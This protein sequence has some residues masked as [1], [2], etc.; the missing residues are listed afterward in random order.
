MFTQLQCLHAWFNTIENK[1]RKKI[2]VEEAE[3]K[4]ICDVDQLRD[5]FIFSIDL[6][7]KGHMDLSMINEMT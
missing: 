2:Y 3:E 1:W 4:S 7:Q 5:I 6:L